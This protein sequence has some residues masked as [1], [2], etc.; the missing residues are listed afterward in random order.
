MG[1]EAAEPAAEGASAV[2]ASKAA[3]VRAEVMSAVALVRVAS[4]VYG[5]SATAGWAA[6]L[7]GGR[8]GDGRLRGGRVI[9]NSDSRLGSGRK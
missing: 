6:R 2:E 5:E 8:Y 1:G 9:Q 7:G 3:M 4:T